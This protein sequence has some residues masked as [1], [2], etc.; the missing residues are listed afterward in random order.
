M[1]Y[2]K[3]KKH[4][5]LEKRIKENL[6]KLFKSAI[7]QFAFIEPYLVFTWEIFT[8]LKLLSICENSKTYMEESSE[9]AEVLKS[10]SRQNFVINCVTA[11]EN[12]LKYRI[13]ELFWWDNQVCQKLEKTKNS[14]NWK[15]SLNWKG[16]IEL[17]KS[18]DNFQLLFEEWNEEG[19]GKGGRNPGLILISTFSFQNIYDINLVISKIIGKDFFDEVESKE[20]S[21]PHMYFTPLKDLIDCYK[22]EIERINSEKNNYSGGN[23]W[24]ATLFDISKKLL[25]KQGKFILKRE[26]PDWKLKMQKLF[27]VRNEFVHYIDSRN[28]SKEEITDLLLVLD[29]LSQCLEYFFSEFSDKIYEPLIELEYEFEF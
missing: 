15:S 7:G 5:K 13:L 21:F 26:H 10:K 8:A 20:V 27:E 1:K 14:T 2:K 23:N 24:S 29:K 3:S 17:L 9:V 25:E 22:K 6:H 12:Y 11:L 18:K 19:Q 4:L 16:I 28:L